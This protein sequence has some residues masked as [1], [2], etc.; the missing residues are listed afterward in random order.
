MV[1]AIRVQVENRQGG[2]GPRHSLSLTNHAVVVSSP[3]KIKNTLHI[4][5]LRLKRLVE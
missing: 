1:E 4:T 2:E 5:M 3:R